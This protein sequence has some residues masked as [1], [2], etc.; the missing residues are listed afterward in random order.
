MAQAPAQDPTFARILVPTDFSP[1][2]QDAMR[3]AVMMAKRFGA[4]ISALHVI[5]TMSYAMTESLQ[6]VDLYAHVRTLVEPMM[7]ELVRDLREKNLTAV[8]V[9]IQGVAYDEIIKKAKEGST[10]LIVM[11]THGRRGVRHLLLGSVAERVVRAS[12]CPVLTVRGD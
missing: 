12:P 9:V 11:G 7:D 2:S 6:W 3:Y 1:C 4:S 10:D 8:G 5:E